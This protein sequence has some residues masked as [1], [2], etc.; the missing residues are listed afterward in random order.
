[1]IHTTTICDG[2][3]SPG[4]RPIV[5]PRCPERG[6]ASCVRWMS[7]RQP[8]IDR[9]RPSKKPLNEWKFGRL[10]AYE[11]GV[12]TGLALEPSWPDI[13]FQE[14]IKIAFR[15]KMISEWNQP[16]LRRLRGEA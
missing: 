1:M 3:S 13:A 5:T 7:F 16:V 2:C 11:I 6:V 9:V 12:A 4:S 8:A 14:I 15:D 10:I